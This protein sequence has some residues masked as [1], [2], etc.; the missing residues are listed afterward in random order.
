L[1]F[2]LYYFIIFLGQISVIVDNIENPENL[3]INFGSV[4]EKNN[5]N[6][7]DSVNESIMT[8]L[9]FD[10][11]KVNSKRINSICFF[12]NEKA[13]VG[14]ERFENKH[15]DVKQINYP[16]KKTANYHIE[17][18]AESSSDNSYL[19]YIPS[20]IYVNK[21]DGASVLFICK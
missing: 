20:Y 10:A 5:N 19:A 11:T 3:L 13:L 17:V 14:F 12:D 6:Y 2:Y 16:L 8:V 1:N 15:R 7:Y 21:G 4:L 18:I 9:F